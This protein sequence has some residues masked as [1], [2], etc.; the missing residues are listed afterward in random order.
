MNKHVIY[1][2]QGM[3]WELVDGT[4]PEI[5][6][7]LPAMFSLRDPE[8]ATVQADRNYSHGGGWMPLEG[9][10]L[11][12]DENG[13]HVLLY[14]PNAPEP[15]PEGEDPP[16]QELARTELRDEMILLFDYGFVV[17]KQKDGSFEIARMD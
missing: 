8:P 1:P 3:M 17:V 12:T 5:L 10:Q 16:L 11:E 15:E 6:G 14:R 4:D 13:R 9:H 7:L 2:G